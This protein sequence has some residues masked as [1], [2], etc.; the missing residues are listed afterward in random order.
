MSGQNGLWLDDMLLLPTK[1]TPKYTSSNVVV[2]PSLQQP[3]RRL[4]SCCAIFSR[5][6]SGRVEC[7]VYAR[8]LRICC[9]P[10]HLP[11]RSAPGVTDV[12][13]KQSNFKSRCWNV[14][15]HL[16]TN[17]PEAVVVINRF[18]QEQQYNTK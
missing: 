4:V 8:K 13:S 3:K 9:L 11:L 6:A 18:R 17:Q 10:G 16:V 5:A 15:N 14:T 7:A 12:I 2:R 1:H